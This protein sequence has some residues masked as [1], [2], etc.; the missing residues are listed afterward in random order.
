[1]SEYLRQNSGL[2]SWLS[3]VRRI[4]WMQAPGREAQYS[5]T[6]ELLSKGTGWLTLWGT[7]GVGKTWLLACAINEFIQKKQQGVYI[8]GGALLDNLR[9]S[10]SDA[11][12]SYAFDQWSSCFALAID[13][14]DAYHKTGWA[15]DKYRQLLEK[16]YNM[17]SE[18]VTIFACNANPGGRDWPAELGWLASRMSQFPIV[19]AGGGD[20]RPLLKGEL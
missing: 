1:M 8:T 9:D 3:H 17:A 11:G 6:M 15:Q 7:Y 12:Y 2:K 18:S 14:T 13:E 5:A 16:R 10:Y 19:E 20:V 4:D